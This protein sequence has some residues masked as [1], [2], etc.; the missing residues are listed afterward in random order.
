MTREQLAAILYRYAKS[1]G[2]DVSAAGDLSGFSDGGSVGSFAA[3]AVAWA[4]AQGLI[5]GTAQKQLLPQASAT[6][7]QT[8]VILMRFQ[9]MLAKSAS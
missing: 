8:A 1:Q 9:Q 4:N 7:A 5:S 6:R 2:Q 3:S